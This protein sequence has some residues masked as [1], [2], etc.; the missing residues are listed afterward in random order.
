V[1]LHAK[2]EAVLTGMQSVDAENEPLCGAHLV[3]PTSAAATVTGV[4]GFGAGAGAAAAAV[5]VVSAAGVLAREFGVSLKAGT[6]VVDVGAGAAAAKQHCNACDSCDDVCD[7]LNC[8]PCEALHRRVRVLG[9][10]LGGLQFWCAEKMLLAEPNACNWGESSDACGII[11]IPCLSL[12]FS[13]S[14]IFARSLTHAASAF[15]LFPPEKGAGSEVHEG[16]DD[17]HAVP[18]G[19][20]QFSRILLD[21]SQ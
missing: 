15:F 9:F 4:A 12:C 18:S 3:V 2:A 21:R 1:H 6:P 19:S 5:A 8:T 16:K 14:V 17:V 11:P 7:N 13:L 20:A 10:F